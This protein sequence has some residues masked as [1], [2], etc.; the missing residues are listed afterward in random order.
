MRVASGLALMLSCQAGPLVA[1]PTPAPVTVAV[2][3]PAKVYGAC[4]VTLAHWYVKRFPV[5]AGQVTLPFRYDAGTGT[6]SILNS[7]G[8]EMAVEGLICGPDATLQSRGDR[9]D[10]RALARSGA[11]P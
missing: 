3:V 1:A 9:L 5:E 11:A 8:I 2:A 7:K 6:V 10:F 4:E